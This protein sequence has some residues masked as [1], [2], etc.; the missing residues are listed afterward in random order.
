[1]WGEICKQ[2]KVNYDDKPSGHLDIVDLLDCTLGSENV[3]DAI[4][5]I[6]H[7]IWTLEISHAAE[8][9]S[10]ILSLRESLTALEQSFIEAIASLQPSTGK[11]VDDKDKAACCAFFRNFRNIFTVNYHLLLYWIILYE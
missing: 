5:W 8:A 11:A 3:E 2:T 9:P 4:A 6:E 7:A 1:D 10:V